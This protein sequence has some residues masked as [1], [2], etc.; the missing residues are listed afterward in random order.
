MNQAKPASESGQNVMVVFASEQLWPNLEGALHWHCY[1]GG[2][3]RLFIYATADAHRSQLPAR[4]LL[5]ILRKT[6]PGLQITCL[7]TGGTRPD[8]V[9]DQLRRWHLEVGEGARWVVNATCGL[10]LMLDG[11]TSFS[12]LTGA[13][14]I[15]REL[16][17]AS[18]CELLPDPAGGALQ[19]IPFQVD[20]TLTG[21]LP[22][23]RL[24]HMQFESPADSRWHSD[25]PTPLPIARIIQNGIHLDWD[26]CRAFELAGQPRPGVTGGFLFEQLMA[27]IL[28]EFGVA[29]LVQNLALVG[30]DGI[31][32]EE[33][34]IVA[35]H[36]GQLIILDCKLRGGE[37]DPGDEEALVLQINDAASTRRQLGGLNAQC[38]LVRPTRKFTPDQANLAKSLGLK[39]W[40]ATKNLLDEI[41]TLLGVPIPTGLLDVKQALLSL[42]SPPFVRQGIARR[43]LDITTQE[44]SSPILNLSKTLQ[45]FMAERSRNWAAFEW[46]GQ[47][48]LLIKW[49]PPS[50]EKNPRQLFYQR[51][52][53]LD[54]VFR[55][56][57]IQ[58]ST[59]GTLWYVTLSASQLDELHIVRNF[60]RTHA[61]SDLPL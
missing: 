26:L 48:T 6:L 41:S 23:E 9:L 19:T 28:L 44:Y 54:E 2:L 43:H 15:Y 40:D 3:S 57:V 8:E 11:A 53:N 30:K 59:N 7:D 46:R 35:N 58:S 22:V 36:R 49:H 51:L 24:V 37:D 29:N 27:A 39:V 34:D 45:D 14:L 21:S 56:S 38:A 13:R 12:R 1:C 25:P 31:T 50:T 18:W 42:H 4:R 60:L 16:S 47:L 52:V 10:K 33:I 61:K 55:K 17:A 5:H 32:L 20:P